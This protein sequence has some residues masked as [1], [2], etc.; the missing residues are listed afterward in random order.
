MP[1]AI[2]E[3]QTTFIQIVQEKVGG[4]TKEEGL[5]ERGSNSQQGVA[6]RLERNTPL[7]ETSVSILQ[8]IQP[9]Q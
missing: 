5:K 6:V 2:A 7:C 9:F 4:V 8:L 3:R 1:N